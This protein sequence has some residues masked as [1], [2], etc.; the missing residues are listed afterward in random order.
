[1]NIRQAISKDLDDIKKIAEACAIDM[2]NYSIFQWNEK[3]PSKEVFKNDIDSGSLY[4]LEN[5]KQIIGCIMLTAFKD[6]VYKDVQWLTKD[7]KNLYLHRLAVDPCFQKNGNGKKLMD[8]AES[9]AVEN[10]FIS[11]RLDTFSLN[12]RNNKFYKSRGYTQLGNVFFPM[13]SDL[14]FHCYEKVLL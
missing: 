1:M 5:N 3:Y 14:P 12:Q 11:I 8:F 2:A 7:S 6:E 9:F 13:Q 10:N 4:V